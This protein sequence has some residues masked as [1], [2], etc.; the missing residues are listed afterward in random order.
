MN[1]KYFKNSK[2]LKKLA[3]VL[4]FSRYVLAVV[5]PVIVLVQGRQSLGGL[6][7]WVLIIAGVMD[8]LDGPIARKSGLAGK[9]FWG[10]ADAPADLFLASTCFVS[11]YVAGVINPVWLLMILLAIA[12]CF[13][14]F[15]VVQPFSVFIFILAYVVFASRENFY[16]LVP[17]IISL[18]LYF[19]F[20]HKRIIMLI[21]RFLIQMINLVKRLFARIKPKDEDDKTVL[22]T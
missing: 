22:D 3:D 4:T 14:S 7:G 17:T 20:S 21:R 11:L 9:G 15:S 2:N 12:G 5:I 19:I 1:V 10:K 16:F 18:S 6:A 13:Y 8:W